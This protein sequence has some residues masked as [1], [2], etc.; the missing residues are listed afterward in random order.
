LP[1]GDDV[2]VQVRHVRIEG[3]NGYIGEQLARLARRHH[4]TEPAP[5]SDPHYVQ[6]KGQYFQRNYPEHWQR[7]QGVLK[8]FQSSGSIGP[9]DFSTLPFNAEFPGACSCVFYPSKVSKNGHNQVCRG[10]EFVKG[11][12][13]EMFGLPSASQERGIMADPYI[14]EVYPDKGYPSLY[15]C[16]CDLLA[17]CMDG[18]NSEGLAGFILV[19]KRIPIN[20]IRIGGDQV[21]GHNQMQLLRHVLDHCATVKEAKTLLLSANLHHVLKGC[22]FMIADASGDSFIF[23]KD[24]RDQR[25]YFTDGEGEIQ[26]MTNHPVHNQASVEAMAAIDY[27]DPY[28]SE[29]RYCIL[30]EGIQ[31]HTGSFTRTD[32]A[33]LGERVFP[34]MLS[35]ELGG[36]K[37]VN[38]PIWQVIYDLDERSMA[39]RFYLRDGEAHEEGGTKSIMSDFYHFSLDPKRLA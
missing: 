18:V 31:E 15:I 4:G 1:H 16:C 12:V 37:V 10:M 25:N 21:V 26:I 3:S 7:I 33:T 39:V 32:M 11:T 6:A 13:K 23:E 5:F 17:G 27:P 35:A 28:T 9:W 36:V 34:R 29:N 14:V 24:H 19:D 20:D 8:T 30:H 2:Y 38:R 22:H